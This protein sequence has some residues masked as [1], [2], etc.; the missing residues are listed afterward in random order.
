MLKTQVE[1]I[2]RQFI[3]SLLRQTCQFTHQFGHAHGAK[4][5]SG[6]D[7]YKPSGSNNPPTFRSVVTRSYSVNSQLTNSLVE[8]GEQLV[9]RG[10]S[11]VA[12]VRETE[13]R[14]FDFSVAAI[15]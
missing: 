14:A 13:R 15:N 2:C 9:H 8:R 11:F 4:V 3:L 7:Y 1:K 6:Y 5:S 10:F 12:H